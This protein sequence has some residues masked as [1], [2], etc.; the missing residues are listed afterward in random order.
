MG[1]L[2]ILYIWTKDNLRLQGIHYV[3][4]AKNIC[5]LVTHGM[6]GNFIENTWGDVVG[7][8]LSENG[9]GFIYAH[10]RGY[11]HINDIS[12]KEI[13]EDGGYKTARIGAT[14][15]RFVDCVYD[16]D[17]WLN[18]VRKLGYKRIILL[19]HSLGCNKT[20]YYLHRNKQ[21]DTVG[22][23]LASPPDMV[24]LAKKPEY[25]SN[26]DELLKEAKENV[27]KGEPRKLLSGLVWD[28]FSL[29]S[30]T[31]LDLAEEGG[32]ADN[33]PVLRNPKEFPELAS[34]D[35]PILAI[36]GEHDDIAI[37]T[38]QDDLDLIELKA[39][40]CPSFTKQFIKNGNHNYER[41]E[42]LFANTILSWIS[43]SRL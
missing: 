43:N 19:G 4:E 3:P 5:V 15:E 6:S 11:N 33:L 38:L 7:Q 22:V 32:P 23:I 42:E 41:Q 31:F 24:G 29:S 17:T 2:N 40:S 35:I 39:T 8:K 36:M 10:N 30:Q 14:Y 37:N 27:K 28:W 34:I 13:K 21:K 20:I 25:Q 12:T 1:K 26:Y 18:Q 9:I 16:I